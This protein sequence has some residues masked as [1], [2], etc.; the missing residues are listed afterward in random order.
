MMERGNLQVKILIDFE[1]YNLLLKKAEL[2]DQKVDHKVQAGGSLAQIVA[3]NTFKEGLSSEPYPKGKKQLKLMKGFL[4][5]VHC[6]YRHKYC[7]DV[8]L[9]NPLHLLFNFWRY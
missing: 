5:I 7:K 9:C 1:E 6:F 4:L 2:Y 3:D 8:F